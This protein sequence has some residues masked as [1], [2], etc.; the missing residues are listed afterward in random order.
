MR[1]DP[2]D[3]NCNIHPN[4]E[5]WNGVGV[6]AVYHKTNIVV[7]DGC[8]RLDNSVSSEPCNLAVSTRMFHA[9]LSDNRSRGWITKTDE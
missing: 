5:T 4:L 3:A 1:P 9:K 2:G 8:T 7:G 6:K